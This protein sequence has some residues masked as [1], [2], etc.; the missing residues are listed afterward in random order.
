[1]QIYNPDNTLLLDVPVDD[2]SL[3]FKEIM[4]DNNLTLKLSLNTF[5][6][7]HLGSWCEFK[8]EQYLLFT[9]ENFI[10]QHTEHFDYTL[11]LEAW[12]AY[13]RF[14]KFK[15][16]LLEKNPG[17]PD[18]LIGAPKTKFSL[19]AT[20]ADFVQLLVD[21]MNFS[22]ITGWQVGEC[23]ESDPVT[24]DFNHDYCNNVLQKF[25]DA[26]N[27]EWEVENKTIHLRKVERRD[28]D[29]NRISFAL[30]YGYKNGILGGISRKQY[31]DSKVINR[32]WV[33]GGDR[34]I[35]YKTYGNDT[36][37]LPKNRVFEYDGKQYRTDAT[38]SYMEPV[39]RKGLLSEDSLDISKIYPKRVGTV[40]EVIEVDDQSGLYD[41]IDAS[42]P[43]NLDYSKMIIPG[44]TMT[45]V[46]QTGALTGKE[47]DAKYIHSTRKFQ[48]VPITDNGLIYPQGSIIPEA[49]DKYAVFHMSLPQEYIDSAETE[50]Q[51]ETVKYLFENGQPKYTYQWNLD[52]IYAK[53]QWG[54]IGGYL[55]PGYFVQFSDDQFM[56][57]PADI[58]ITSVK[59]YIN[60]PKSPTI[61][62]SNN[63]TGKSL[64]SVIHQIPAKE[65]ETDRK[66]NEVR[67]YA[68]RRWRDT[69]ELI[70]GIYGMTDEFEENLLSALVFEGM[71]FR[72]GAA[73][74]QYR[75][76]ADDW[77]TSI[78]PDI[79]F[80]SLDKRFYAPA[81]KIVHETIKIDGQKLYWQIPAY[82]SDA[83]EAAK[84]YYLYLRCSK[85]LSLVD[86]R[87]TGEGIFFISEDK[88]KIED[89]EGF[90]TFWVAFVNS[91]NEE[92]TR[93]FST[94]YGLSEL[95][96]GQLTVD[97]IISSDGGSFWKAL[98]NQF[99]L[100]DNEKGI[101]WNVSE[102]GQLSI[103]GNV[104][105]R[106][107]AILSGWRFTNENIR[108]Q[109]DYFVM[110]PTGAMSFYSQLNGKELGWI[111]NS[112]AGLGIVSRTPEN[113]DD[114][115]KG[116]VAEFDYNGV[117]F[118]TEKVNMRIYKAPIYGEVIEFSEP[119]SGASF[120][121]YLSGTSAPMV[122]DMDGGSRGLRVN[123]RGLPESKQGLT[124]GSGACWRDANNDG[125]IKTV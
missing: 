56:T 75:F 113:V 89:T 73:S 33:Q 86:G 42:I 47:F 29:G 19:T 53:E 48:L 67:E 63:V 74:L 35:N 31:D 82:N 119:D 107:V 13:L 99:K 1:M 77:Q 108:S 2:S 61:E 3:R 110:K 80:N 58:R 15:F 102:K 66:D 93:S 111:S 18:K 121:I 40:S 114:Y 76:L 115:R 9:P 91:E 6:D 22:G 105:V 85:E 100:G 71:V 27:T 41:I 65:Q 116:Q 101:D 37:L 104:N 92:G 87:L 43:E 45:V 78:E 23:L 90:Y 8:G 122:V 55:A 120:R 83:L 25:A 60:K 69:Q 49:E 98:K 20:P 24:I 7:A 112:G 72:A 46:F 14:V 32:L 51:N 125:T 4:G 62:I 50:A 118:S 117:R 84:P 64:S 36:L 70:E 103:F 124:A 106:D 96:P 88:I 11:I 28:T 68:K 52:G 30:S 94:M 59:E 97:T 17:E 57:E 79:Y 5:F 12:Q 81:S 109:N 54:T 95:L 34:N 123:M 38:G 39:D 44:E 26:F 21:N 16:I 10:K